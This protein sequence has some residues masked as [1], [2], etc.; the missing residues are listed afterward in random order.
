MSVWPCSMTVSTT[1]SCAG[2]AR[3]EIVVSFHP[4]AVVRGRSANGTCRAKTGGPAPEPERGER[5]GRR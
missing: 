1:S 3:S 2:V 4:G 5:I